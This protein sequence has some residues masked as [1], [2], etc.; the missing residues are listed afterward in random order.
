MV[1][2]DDLSAYKGERVRELIGERGCEVVYLRPY[3]PDF[4]PIGQTFSK[5]KASLAG[6]KLAPARR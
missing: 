2:M 4:N 5:L 6:P 3:S 1:E